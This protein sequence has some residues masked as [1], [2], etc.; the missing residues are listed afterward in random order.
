MN[1]KCSHLFAEGE[2]TLFNALWDIAN[3][4]EPIS[5]FMPNRFGKIKTRE[6]Q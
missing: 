2:F 1:L 5:Y 4:C 6:I 3:K